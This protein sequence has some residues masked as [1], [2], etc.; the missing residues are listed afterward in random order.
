MCVEIRE[1]S[2]VSESLKFITVITFNAAINY[3]NFLL[4]WLHVGHYGNIFSG[5]A[6][7]KKKMIIKYI[8][9]CFF[10]EEV[11]SLLGCRINNN[12]LFFVDKNYMVK[13]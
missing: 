10:Y 13:I 6:Q 4:V 8:Y 5:R 1:F 7:K 11:K 12:I 2:K 3:K 9:A